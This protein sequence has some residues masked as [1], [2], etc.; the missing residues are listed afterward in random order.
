M[1]TKRDKKGRIIKGSGLL[2]G[3]SNNYLYDCW[4]NMKARCHRESH[5][6][7][8]YYG[9]KGIMVCQEWL[10]DF[11]VFM[12]D[13]GDRPTRFHTLDR[14]DNNGGYNKSN[15][16]WVTIQEQQKNR[17][18]NNEYCGVFFE[19]DRNKW[20]ADIKYKGKRFF[21][22][23][24]TQVQDAINARNKKEKELWQIHS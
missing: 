11:S 14:I 19:T 12:E 10:N 5:P 23:R 4:A 6:M 7:F 22:G 13:V 8:K 18:N 24:F 17:S 21:L 15:C 16:R 20:R 2:H 1:I 3:R 9:A